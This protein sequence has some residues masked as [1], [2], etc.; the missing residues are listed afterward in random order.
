MKSGMKGLM[1]VLSVIG[2]VSILSVIGIGIFI[3]LSPESDADKFMNNMRDMIKEQAEA[4]VDLLYKLEEI[5]DKAQLIG[6]KV[7]KEPISIE[8]EN[9]TAQALVDDS[10]SRMEKYLAILQGHYDEL[11][12]KRAPLGAVTAHVAVMEYY[13]SAIKH[14]ELVIK[15]TASALELSWEE[16]IA[17]IEDIDNAFEAADIAWDTVVEE[18]ALEVDMDSN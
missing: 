2:L 3:I 18:L 13:E 6:T 16:D 7:A 8:A 11:E 5:D 14:S 9:A 1:W 4:Q 12:S 15:Y 10:V 17:L